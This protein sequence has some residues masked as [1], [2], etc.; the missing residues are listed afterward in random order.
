MSTAELT[1]SR[2]GIPGSP[3]EAGA[4]GQAARA[5]L[6]SVLTIALLLVVLY[7]AFEHG[8]VALGV[9]AR[10]QVVIGALAAAAGAAWLWTGTLRLRAPRLAVA[11]IA[12]LAAFACWS[13]ITL[14]WSVAPNQTWIELDRAIT[15]VITLCLAIALGAS[16]ARAIRDLAGGYLLVA[17]AVTAYAL[18]Q[19][20]LPG[21]HVGGLFDLNQTG[22]LPRLQEPLGYWNALALFVVMAIPVAL[23]FA[24]DM[25]RAPRV[26]VAALCA[27]ELMLL[28]VALTYS[29][30]GLLALAAALAVGIGAA[31]SGFA[32]S[33]GWCSQL[34]ATVPPLVFGL[35][36]S[37][38]GR[39]R[40]ARRSRGGRR[41][42]ALILAASLLVLVLVSRR[43]LAL[44]PRI[45]IGPERRPAVRR[46]VLA[47]VALA[48]IGALAAVSLSSRGSAETYRTPGTRSPR[49][50]RPA[51]RTRAGCSR[52]IRRTD[53]CGGR[54]RGCVQ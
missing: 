19:K 3:T 18:G 4:S 15:Y 37:V 12:L 23:A 42:A 6:P 10:I 41:R 32:R 8:A 5:R 54:R 17:L 40:V 29:R 34:S 33:S 22:P 43:L 39:R 11:G 52:P 46:L 49:P 7:A 28:V 38:D 44:E 26:R 16:Y 47:L 1:A 51:T 2:A 9:E 20:L 13:G 36:R 53:G 31:E 24:G 21:L 25:R 45:E 30:G 14:A 27:V 50:R 35:E 48:V